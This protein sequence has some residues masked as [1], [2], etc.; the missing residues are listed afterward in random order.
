S[1][2]RM[3]AKIWKSL[4]VTS[5]LLVLGVV[6]FAGYTTIHYLRTSPRFEVKKV[7]VLGLRRVEETQVLTKA[8]LPDVA[9]GFSVDL[10]GVRERVEALKWVRFATVQRVLPD[11][12]AIKIVER[13]PVG[14]ARIH[15][16]LFQFDAQAELLDQDR[17]AGVNFP[18]LDGLSPDDSE[19]NQKKV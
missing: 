8:G 7:S 3:K 5:G 19:A 15:G 10:E 4:L 6:G 18:I 2:S 17:G 9:N 13:E 1:W 14:L 11:T 16:E 12:I